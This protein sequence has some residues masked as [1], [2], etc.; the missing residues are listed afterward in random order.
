MDLNLYCF[1]TD[2]FCL[3]QDTGIM[4]WDAV[5]HVNAMFSHS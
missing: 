4:K 5:S 1:P 3:G 2:I